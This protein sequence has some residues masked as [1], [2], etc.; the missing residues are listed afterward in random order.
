LE[1]VKSF[2]NKISDSIL[3]SQLKTGDEESFSILFERYYGSLVNYGKTLMSGE[4]AVKDCVQDVFVDV[5]KYSEKLD[6]AIVVK[7]YLFSCVRNR[8]ARLHKRDHIFSNIKDVESF[9]FMFDFSIE[10]RL[11]ADENMANKVDQL[12]SFINNLPGRQ[13]EA[14]YLRYHQGLTVEQ[15]AE[16]LEMNYQ[17]TK[18]LLHRAISRL[19]NDFPVSL[20]ALLLN[21][22]TN[23]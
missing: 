21:S 17:S 18:N 14:L 7:A 19:R 6:T 1:K 13:K 15:V 16:V 12:N 9:D 11:I 4:D 3:W 2:N 5:W 20:L 22:P 23:F 8:I 10:D